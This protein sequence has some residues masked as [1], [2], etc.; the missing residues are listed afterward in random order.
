MAPN[1]AQPAMEASA[2]PPRLW[3]IKRAAASKKS[4]L[5]P[6]AKHR[7]AINR[8]IGNTPSS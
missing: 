5:A 7:C 8:N 3:P 6:A 4:R 2:N 1:P